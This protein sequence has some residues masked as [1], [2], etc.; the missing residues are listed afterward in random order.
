MIPATNGQST[1]G[2]N[3]MMRLL[4]V[5]CMLGAEVFAYLELA[6]CGDIKEVVLFK[7]DRKGLKISGYV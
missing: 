1:K 5:M 2:H 7:T 4:N 6:S 3:D